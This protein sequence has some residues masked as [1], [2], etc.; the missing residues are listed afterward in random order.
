MT[1]IAI[2]SSGK[3]ASGGRNVIGTLVGGGPLGVALG[4]G[5]VDLGQEQPAQLA[6]RRLVEPVE[7][8][9]ARGW[10]AQELVSL[11]ALLREVLLDLGHALQVLALPAAEP[12]AAR[13]LDRPLLHARQRRRRGR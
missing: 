10:L 11:E 7:E 3:A 12:Q 6:P 5:A 1:Q 2:R 9:A 8:P 13:P 4:Q